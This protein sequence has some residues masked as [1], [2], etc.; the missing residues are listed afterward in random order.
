M[1]ILGQL[2]GA[3]A[4]AAASTIICT[5]VVFKLPVPAPKTV[6]VVVPHAVSDSAIAEAKQAAEHE[7]VQLVTLTES[8]S[9]RV[10]ASEQ[11]KVEGYTAEDVACNTLMGQVASLQAANASGAAGMLYLNAAKCASEEEVVLK[12]YESAARNINNKSGAVGSYLDCDEAVRLYAAC[13]KA[14]APA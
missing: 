10:E 11:E 8:L 7:A 4:A 2:F 14:S 13:A 1:P 9:Q 5:E 12:C 6:A 3:V